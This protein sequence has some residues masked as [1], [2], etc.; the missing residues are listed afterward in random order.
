LEQEAVLKSAAGWED[1]EGGWLGAR[2]VVIV[3][4]SLLTNGEC[5]ADQKEDAYR[6][7]EGLMSAWTVSR[8]DVAHFV[9]EKLFADWERWAGK[10]W[11][12]SY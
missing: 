3:R 6:V 4:P 12:V 7:D 2:N 8:A 10:A 9:A 11:V 5:V 1:Y